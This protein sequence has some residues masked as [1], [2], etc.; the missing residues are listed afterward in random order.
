MIYLGNHDVKDITLAYIAEHHVRKVFT[1]G[2]P[3]GIDGE[4]CVSWVDCIKY[5]HYNRLRA[6]IT[7]EDLV[8]MNDALCSGDR[9]LLH[10]NCIRQYMVQT[11]HRLIFQRVPFY[12][13]KDDVAILFDMT[14]NNPF[15][16]LPISEVW[17]ALKPNWKPL[18]VDAV[19]EHV[20]LTMEEEALYKAQKDAIFAKLKGSPCLLPRQCLRA[21]ERLTE[22]H[23]S[24]VTHLSDFDIHGRYIE[25]QLGVDKYHADI[26]RQKLE[27]LREYDNE[28]A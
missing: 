27:W 14:Q 3:I 20:E 12:D 18:D 21:S 28:Y 6:T 13:H 4:D 11:Q 2:E 5:I 25:N 26:I 19:I 24:I 17:D 10:F 22:R 1:I 8:V 7:A 23:R 16:K 15:L 9:N